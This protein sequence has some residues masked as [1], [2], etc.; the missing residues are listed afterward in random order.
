M[1]YCADGTIFG[2]SITCVILCIYGL[3]A[4]TLRVGVVTD[5][6]D[7]M[8]G[9][10][11]VSGSKIIW[12]TTTTADI[13]YILIGRITGHPLF[14][15]DVTSSSSLSSTKTIVNKRMGPDCCIDH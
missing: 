6:F 7:T 13:V 2:V 14:V 12:Y 9:H 4:R 3:C 8:R 1:L 5:L 10:S 15:T 11:I